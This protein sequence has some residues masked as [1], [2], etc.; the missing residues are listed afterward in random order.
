MLITSTDMVVTL[1]IPNIKT[2]VLYRGASFSIELPHSLFGGNTEGQ[3]GTCDNSQS[4]DCRSPNGQV[5][6]C[7]TSAGHWQIPGKP[8]KPPST[9]TSP[10]LTSSGVTYSTTRPVC[11]PVICDLL[12]SNVFE[13]CHKVIP[14]KPFVT[15]CV[16]DICNGNNETCS[17]MEAYASECSKAGVCIDWR[18]QTNGFCEHKCPANKV[19]KACG[20]EVEKTCNDR[21][22]NKYKANDTLSTNQGQEGCFCSSGTTLFNTVYD[23]CVTSCDVCVG[24]D[25][26]PQE[27]G[28]TWISGCNKCVCDK[29]SMSIQCESV[30]CPAEVTVYCTEPGQQVVNKTENCCSQQACECN[31]NLCPK[32]TSC[33]LGWTLN[34]TNGVCCQEYKCV[35]KGICVY[36]MTEYKPGAKIPTTQRLSEG[37]LAA[38]PT[39]TLA[40]SGTEAPELEPCQECYCGPEINPNTSLHIIVCTPI[41]CNITCSEGYEYQLLPGQCC[42]QC[43]QKSCILTIYNTTVTIE[44]NKT[45][46][47]PDDK[48]VEYSC[49]NINGQLVMKETKTT[50]PAFNPFD[51]EPGTEKTDANG[52]CKSCKLRSIC[53]VR[54]NQTVI[55]VNGCKSKELIN[56]TFCFGHCESS[57]VYSAA[58][59]SMLR[60]CECC[61]ETSTTQR[62]V[63]LTCGDGSNLQHN[64]TT[65]ETCACTQS[66]CQLGTKAKQRRRRR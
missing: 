34:V 14:P 22:N 4:N 41:V 11:K 48:C 29:D 10:P 21:Y 65:T 50:C 56:L 17:N 20:P 59:N 18:N 63:E 45:F 66:D 55:E 2:R 58:A 53:E 24:P 60:E 9:T 31:S 12:T 47:Y 54:S 42:G 36:D 39:T 46:V 8:C 15:S 49:E 37:P 62:Q 61:Q 1:E 52:C 6:S 51:C 13:P 35:P 7:S 26:K 40:P 5:E 16:S 3:C 27:P 28:N 19:Y 30:Q 57:S 33:P 32:P 38:P 43:A 44:V 23:T 64:Y 25:G